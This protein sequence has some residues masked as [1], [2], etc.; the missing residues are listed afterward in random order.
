MKIE[1]K[2]ENKALLIHVNFNAPEKIEDLEEFKLLVH[3]SGLIPHHII[4]T[5]RQTPTAKYFI[6]SGKLS[7]IKELL[8]HDPVSVALVNHNLSPA[9]SRNLEEALGCRVIDRTELILD[10]FA[11]RARTSEGMLQVELAQLKHLSTRL[12]RGWTHLERQKGG[13]GLRGPG[14]AQLETDRRLIK[15]RISTI[16]S[17]LD[18]VAEQRNQNRRARQKQS[19]PSVALI[20]YTNAG[21][22]TLFNRL[23]RSEV[24]VADQLFATLDPTSRRC[25]IPNLGNII[26]I[27]TVGFIRHLPPTLIKAFKATLEETIQADLLLHVV[28]KHDPKRHEHKEAVLSIIQELGAEELPILEVYNK[29]DLVPDAVAET[30]YDENAKPIRVQLSSRSGAGIPL[31]YTALKDL[32]ITPDFRT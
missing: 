19:T 21:K 24:Y 28:D 8:N 14:E 31:L 18:K 30:Y 1:S 4:Q 12:V 23:T 3:S 2:L 9:Q 13:I 29:L 26:L 6:G 7:E 25:Y 32:L 5:T 22:S 20:G 10:I 17:R 11:Q 27:D 15:K 16:N